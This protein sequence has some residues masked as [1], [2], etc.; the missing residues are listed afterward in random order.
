MGN[1][2]SVESDARLAEAASTQTTATTSPTLAFGK[3]VFALPMPLVRPPSKPATIWLAM[4][5]SDAPG[6]QMPREQSPSPP[7]PGS[8]SM[9][10]ASTVR[11]RHR[12]LHVTHERGGHLTD[13]TD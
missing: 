3:A 11:T 2:R 5:R 10:V 6:S 9:L 8:Y 7:G 12:D 4:S 13:G 1:L